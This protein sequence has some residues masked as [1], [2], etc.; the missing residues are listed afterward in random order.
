[1]KDPINPRK[2]KLPIYSTTHLADGTATKAQ[3]FHLTIC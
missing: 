1:M 2:R 3:D